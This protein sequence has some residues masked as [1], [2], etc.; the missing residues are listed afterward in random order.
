MTR[1]EYY[2]NLI[3]A[4]RDLEHHGVKGQSWGKR[5]YQNPDGTLTPLGREH[6]GYGSQ[7]DAFSAKATAAKALAKV[8]EVN[9][10]T[11][12]N[13]NKT[14]SSMNAAAK[15][16]Y[17]KKAEEAQRAANEKKYAKHDS[18]MEKYRQKL[19]NSAERKHNSYKKEFDKNITNLRDLNKNGV[20]SEVYKKWKNDEDKRR[21]TEYESKNSIMVDGSTYVKRYSSSGDRF[22]NDMTD[23]ATKETKVKE[24]IDSNSSSAKYNRQQAERWLASNNR[25]K[26]LDRSTV[27]TKRDLKRLYNTR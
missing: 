9:E 1:D 24:L 21:E 27:Y 10:K 8:Y 11:Y 7:K 13:S 5:Q 2:A 23:S 18:K 6:Y 14:L 19:E 20:N 26:N 12:K 15:N 25:L 16:Q 17:L 4:N 22:W 3:K